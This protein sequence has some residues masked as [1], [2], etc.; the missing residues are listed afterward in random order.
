M[1]DEGVIEESNSPWSSP[2]V[3]VTKKDGSTRFCVDYRKLNDVT[4]KNSY[5]LPR[6]HDTLTT[7]SG[8]AW[9]S[10]LH[11]KSGYWQVGIHPKDKEK[12][13]FS[14]GSGLYHFTVMPFELCNA[15][16]TFER[17]MEMVLREL[18]W[19]TCLVYLDDIMVM[20]KTFEEH[21]TNLEEVFSRMKEANLKLN[22][23]KC[24]LFQK[25]VEFLGHTVSSNGI[26][27]TETKIKAICE[28]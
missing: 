10:T 3:L 24:L 20:G 9:F 15:P 6:I 28:R 23:K 5:P 4:K 17:L 13:A 18:T 11:L 19:K 1:L 25:E 7:L 2:V 12:T 26:K 27:T 14:G 22:P 21:L 16:A 8:S